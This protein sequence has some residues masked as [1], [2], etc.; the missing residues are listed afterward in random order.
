MLFGLIYHTKIIFKYTKN[1]F[2]LI[3]FMLGIKKEICCKYKY[4]YGKF[5]L[6]EKNKEISG[7]NLTVIDYIERFNSSKKE[8]FK[9]FLHDLNQDTCVI[10]NVKFRINE[11]SGTLWEYFMDDPFLE[12]NFKDRTV[13]DIGANI[14]DTALWMASKGAEVYA[15]EPVTETYDEALKNLE[16]NPHLKDKVTFINKAVDGEN[17]IIKIYTN[18]NKNSAAANSFV[19]SST[20]VE[21][22][23][24]TIEDILNRYNIQ[25]DIIK[26]DCEG[27]EYSIIEKSDLSVFNKVMV[28]YHELFVKI[29]YKKLIK[30]LKDM[31][32]KVEL[33]DIPPY[34]KDEIGILI[35]KK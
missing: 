23:A 9:E 26:I 27:A 12:G 30:Q 34:K 25:P 22:E 14:G 35:A 1:P 7:K 8:E 10:N 31:G 24:L 3:L 11:F 17:K 20:Y 29:S 2:S 21:I 4:N 28:E 18:G 15:F 33:K 19:E 16:L 6:N 5:F 32:F 13:I